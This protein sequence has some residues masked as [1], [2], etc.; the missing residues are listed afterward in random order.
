MDSNLI[1]FLGLGAL[2]IIVPGPD[3][4]LTI[5]NTL[6]GGRKAGVATAGGVVAGQAVWALATSLGIV[7]LLVA[8]EP[9]FL[10][11]KYAGAAYLILLGIQ[12]LRAAFF[13]PRH[14][15]PGMSMPGR[16][17]LLTPGAAFR[18]GM[19]SDL[20][21]PKIALFFASLL[22][23]FVPAGDASFSAFMQ[24]GLLFCA[25][26]FAWLAAYAAVV[27][28]AGEL[29]L[30]PK[31]RRGIEAVTGTVLIALGLRIATEQ[32]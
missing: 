7:A 10:A 3:T 22:P 24:L 16:A 26:T 28:K 2:V 17:K 14:G 21:N 18:Q 27:A 13:P 9:L 20:G 6:F 25:M 5:R 23:Q 30:R 8:S 1:T 29:L 15:A 31:V 11:I 12:A 4:A 32:R 19:I